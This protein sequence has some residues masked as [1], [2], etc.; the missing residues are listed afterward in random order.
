MFLINS[1]SHLF[2]ETVSRSRCLSSHGTTAHLLPKLRC[3][4]AEFLL[5]S[6]LKRLSI[7]SSPT[8]VGLRYGQH[9]IYLEVFLGSVVSMTSLGLTSSCSYLGSLTVRICLHSLP[10]YLNR[11][12]H[13]SAHL[14]FSVTPSLN[15]LCRYRNIDLFPINYPFRTR[16]RD[17]LTHRGLPCRWKP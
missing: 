9:N 4:F 3:Q 12:I 15:D 7:F 13:K 11:L 16:L 14:T 5:P 2:S 10:T 6:S 1:R 8:S 17:R